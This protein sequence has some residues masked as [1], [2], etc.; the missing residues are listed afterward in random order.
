M[1]AAI[2]AVLVL[3]GGGIAAWVVIDDRDSS[4][5]SASDEESPGD[6][7]SDDQDS[8]DPDDVDPAAAPEEGQCREMADESAAAV[9]DASPLVDC[10]EEHTATT[11]YVGAYAGEE[12]VTDEAAYGCREQLPDAL[13]LS[14]EE[15]ALTAYQYVFFQPTDEQWDDG[16][17][18]F[19]CDIVLPAVEALQPLPT[20]EELV[21][22]PLD[23]E[24]AA[25]LTK[26]GERTPC[27]ETHAFRAYDT[28]EGD[29]DA[30]PT[31]DV[32]I[33]QGTAQCPGATRYHYF[34]WPSAYAWSEGDHLGVCWEPA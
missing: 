7:G 8:T 26:N 5:D 32:L 3:I 9:S 22:D 6:E 21:P 12:P 19:R 20:D 18:W 17:R 2:A 13:G 15:A 1:V 30:L 31:D 16:D 10:T 27:S 34:T 11:Y 14:A 25:C 24:H 4:S 33:K 28:W 23:D 29:G